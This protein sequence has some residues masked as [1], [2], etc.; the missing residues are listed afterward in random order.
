M[1]NFLQICTIFHF[2]YTQYQNFVDKG[3][4]KSHPQFPGQVLTSGQKP[5]LSLLAT[6]TLAYAL[7]LEFLPFGNASWK[8]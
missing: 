1:Y 6:I 7:F 4:T 8:S 5:T 2:F 3:C